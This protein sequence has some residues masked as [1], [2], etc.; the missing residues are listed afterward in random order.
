MGR[1]MLRSGGIDSGGGLLSQG[2]GAVKMLIACH[3]N[4]SLKI[5]VVVI[6]KEGLV[7]G[8]PS[9]SNTTYYLQRLQVTNL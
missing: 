6:P 1:L 3:K 9:I 4:A 5:V 8:T 2:G 7:S